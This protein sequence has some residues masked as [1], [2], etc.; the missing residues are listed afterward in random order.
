MTTGVK[1]TFWCDLCFRAALTV[2]VCDDSDSYIRCHPNTCRR[3]LTDRCLQIAMVQIQ[4]M[5]NHLVSKL[6]AADILDVLALSLGI[7]LSHYIQSMVWTKIYDPIKL[8]RGAL[9]VG[10]W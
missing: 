8:S 5:H 9:V 1:L 3:L 7:C 4:C 10:K 2:V 6:T